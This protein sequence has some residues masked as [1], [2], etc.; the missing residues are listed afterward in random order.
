MQI[1]WLNQ[2]FGQVCGWTQ[3]ANSS[4][5]ETASS[6]D[7]PSGIVRINMWELTSDHLI[8]SSKWLGSILTQT[9]GNLV[10]PH[11]TDF[12]RRNTCTKGRQWVR[13]KGKGWEKYLSPPCRPSLGSGWP[14]VGNF[15]EVRLWRKLLWREKL[16]VIEVI[17][18]TMVVKLIN[19]P[20][21]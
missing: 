7:Y 11:W 9:G 17:R 19:G 14:P 18:S 15:L 10:R 4:V 12:H 6:W 13:V 8:F 5:C 1:H 2:P 21:F 3:S 16:V 20:P